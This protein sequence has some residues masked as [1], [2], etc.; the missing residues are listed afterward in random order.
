MEIHHFRVL[1]IRLMHNTPPH[2]AS[3][4]S[5]RNLFVIEYKDFRPNLFLVSKKGLR[6]DVTYLQLL[7]YPLASSF[8]LSVHITDFVSFRAS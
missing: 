1:V 5:T 7:T 6:F 3:L 2:V 4:S 8:Y